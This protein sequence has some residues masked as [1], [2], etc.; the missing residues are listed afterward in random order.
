MTRIWWIAAVLAAGLVAC[1]T[2]PTATVTKKAAP[3]PTKPSPPP[4]PTNLALGKE[5]A[6]KT[7]QT[8]N[9]LQSFEGIAQTLEIEP[10]QGK[11]NKTEINILFKAPDRFRVQ[12]RPGFENAGLKL[13]FRD[14]GDHLDIRLAGILGVA[15]LTIG[16]DDP[17]ARNSHGHQIMQVS[18]KGILNRLADPRGLVTYVGEAAV[19]GKP[20]QVVS[21]TGP[22]LLKG[23]T[24]ERIHIDKATGVPIR[25]E[26]L[27]GSKL[28]FASTIKSIKL[29]PTVSSDAFDI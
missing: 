10:T 4:T 23:V 28:I 19:E 9:S 7:V 15:K 17:R 2:A 26:M 21:L 27:Q 13:A 16:A 14:G 12:V 25:G 11:T 5:L 8:F 20:T 29:N 22:M 24:A 6:A 3:A 18:E 1:G